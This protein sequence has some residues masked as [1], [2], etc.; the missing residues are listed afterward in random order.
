MHV[1]REKFIHKNIN[2]GCIE[3]FFHSVIMLPETI[4]A[5]CTNPQLSYFI[6]VYL[7]ENQRKN[8]AHFT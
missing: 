7:L 5:T 8:F 4:L 3:L 6:I 1:N 2:G